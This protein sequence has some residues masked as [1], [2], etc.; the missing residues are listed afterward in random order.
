MAKGKRE[1]KGN[2]AGS[3]NSDSATPFDKE[4]YEEYQEKVNVHSNVGFETKYHVKS[5]KDR[6]SVED[7]LGVGAVKYQEKWKEVSRTSYTASHAGHRDRMRTRLINSGFDMNAFASHEIL[8]FLLYHVVPRKNTNDIAHQLI[9]KFGTVA[10]VLDAD[11]LDLKETGLLSDNAVIFLHSL[12]YIFSLYGKQKS[13]G[14]N[15]INLNSA[16]KLAAYIKPHVAFKPEEEIHILL[17]DFR[18]RLISDCKLISIGDTTTCNLDLK[19]I[20]GLCL[21]HRATYFAI[22]HNH[23]YGDPNPSF[24]DIVTTRGLYDYMKEIGVLLVEH[25]IFTGNRFVS[26]AFDGL[27]KAFAQ[28]QDAS[29][30]QNFKFHQYFV[31]DIP[32]YAD[33]AYKANDTSFDEWKQDHQQN[34]MF[35]QEEKLEILSSASHTAKNSEQTKI[36]NAPKAKRKTTVSKPTKN[37]E[38]QTAAPSCVENRKQSEEDKVWDEFLEFCEERGF[39]KPE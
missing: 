14:L 32:D 2:Y 33:I 22:T 15:R 9:D 23:P 3:G 26:F 39:K 27:F 21:R 31:N 34:T 7:S 13:N 6:Y 38:N 10:E 24:D 18:Y 17:M 37:A 30:F 1:D 28:N 25:L 12:P 4:L 11:M 8:E 29:R 20:M 19:K 36:E 5:R 35:F 16:E